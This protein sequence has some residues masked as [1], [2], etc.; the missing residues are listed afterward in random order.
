MSVRRIF[1]EKRQGFFDIPAQQLFSDLVETFRLVDLKAVRII[2]RYDIEGITDEEYELVKNVVFAEPP[3]D[4]VY[5][6]ELPNFPNS[7]AFAVEP[8]PGQ[9]DQTADSAAECVQLVTGRE[10]PEVRTARII[11]LV[12]KLSAG[13]L[14][15]IKDYCINKVECREASLERKNSLVM[16]YYLPSDVEVIEN[17]N[18]YTEA[19]LEDFHRERG[20]AMTLDDLR[21][22]QRYFVEAMHR[23]PT[24]TEIKV[25][26]TY[27][28]DHCRHTTFM[29]A[30][31]EVNIDNGFYALPLREAY[32]KYIDCRR[33]IYTDYQKRDVTLMDLAVI[34]M[35][36]LRKR[37][38]LADLDE[39]DE[40]NACSIRIKVDIE[41]KGKVKPVEYLLMFK[42][43]TH[44]HP[45]EIEP[46]GGAA[47]CLGGA[48]RDPLSGRSYV[49]QAMRVTGAAD[50]R[51]KIE[52]TL[53]GKL[54]QKKITIGAAAGY[55]SYGNQIGLATGQ[56]RELYHPGYV[57]KR[58]E[59][60]AV[61][62]AAPAA[63][64]VRER[65]LAGDI[66]VLLGGRTGRDGIGG[67]TGSS[68][69]H[70][71]TSINTSGAE[72][73]KG[74]PPTE[75]K[76]QRLFRDP[77]VSRLIKKCN[78]FGAGGIAVAIGE[79]ADGLEINLDAVKK[80]YEGL[81][82]TELA[83][84]ESQER[85][86][87]MLSPENVD[88]FIAA[89]D[90]ENLEATVVAKVTELPYLVMKWRDKPIVQIARAFL[91]TNGVRQHVRATIKSPD[92]KKSY[93]QQLPDI[94][95]KAGRN[96]EVTWLENLR[97]LNVCSQKGLAERFDSTVG[98]GAIMMPFGGKNQL[99]PT[100]GMISKIPV[101]QGET[102]T[103]SV[104]SFGFNPHLSEWS[105]FH[106]AVYAVVEAVAK[107]VAMGGE[108][109]TIR[110]T[111]QEY[112]ERLGNEPHKWG[113]P[114][115][116]L[117]GA[118]TA[119]QELGIPAI[120]GKDSMSGTFEQLN[121]PPTL[122]AFA[123]TTMKASDALS[124]EF[125]YP[126][127]KVLLIPA[128]KSAHDL[129][130]FDRLKSN[131]DKIHKLIIGQKV[132]SAQSV[133]EGG[134]A[135]AISKMCVGNGIGFRFTHFMHHDDLF[136]PQYGAILL[137]V[138]KSLNVAKELE[139]TGVIELGKTSDVTSVVDNTSAITVAEII[140]AYTEPL[141]KIFPTTLPPSP[142]RTIDR[143][144]FFDYTD[145]RPMSSVVKLS[146][147]K[148][149]I[150]VFPGTNCEYDS[151]RAWE[152]AGGV[153][154]TLVVRNLSPKAVKETVDAIVKGIKRANIIMLPGGFSGGDEPDGSGKL[155]AA[156]FR[157]PRI[158]EA[159]HEHLRQDDGLILGICNGFQALI[160]LGLLPYGE[161][162]D[163]DEDSP[164]LTYNNLGRHISSM[165]RIKV[166]SN[167]SPWLS[168]VNVGDVHMV[169]ASHG[170]GRFYA[171]PKV[172]AN[173]RIRGQIATQYVDPAG[174][175]TLELPF[176]PN[177]S[178]NAIE[179]ITSPDG[180][181][182]GKMAH[183]ERIGMNIANNIHGDKNQQIFE[184]GVGY[185]TR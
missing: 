123:V 67:A 79:L 182:L 64:V 150:P 168:N 27:W 87:V 84:S 184:A 53:K 159:I 97:S 107:I 176:N 139:G 177:G 140:E 95:K 90:R 56:V 49:Y 35:K 162:R 11:V 88:E 149:F 103:A 47:T 1:V 175:P 166:A 127:N 115:A 94:I 154:E 178:V 183:S 89:A 80:K 100:E 144:T 2:M 52:D 86:A 114:L 31:D 78:D 147:P 10:R 98:A 130:I 29:T 26:D 12:G 70:T 13:E 122:T 174:D 3:V 16:S 104:M 73:Q 116:A 124:P 83:I 74:N 93:L 55:S 8:L 43:E 82:G 81:D 110:L 92:E 106:G 167:L 143:P 40:V 66:I 76:I 152:R 134:I 121:V 32:N 50:P 173:L 112:F 5:E 30:I 63:N 113:K 69:G 65:P 59:I 33:E 126:G 161:I 153:P 163:L 51:G 133:G 102:D 185:F 101:L 20:L 41:E 128:P 23:P 58:M 38:L 39:S 42:N 170:E 132:F 24:I 45:T 19:E 125:K 48:I 171:E 142:V 137:E 129:P 141:E 75:R 111:L 21:Y 18:N 131:F 145:G 9:F 118:F 4:T 68:K 62:G 28:S 44:N 155:I 96:L 151:A 160:K 165:V 77:K 148:I 6:E 17:F 61:I 91:D 105:P 36:T 25:I 172:V 120:G 169:P 138:S 158:K 60:G 34:G 109:A 14:D 22:C 181:I 117:L 180:R 135:A 37:G 146:K 108:A 179:G 46:F 57:A 156:M 136:L 72:V 15:K 99:T 71:T 54:P 164:T 85:M 119:Q 7:V 157:N